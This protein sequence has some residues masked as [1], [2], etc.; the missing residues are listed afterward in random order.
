MEQHVCVHRGG[1]A[2]C[3]CVCV[4]VFIVGDMPCVCVF[5]PHT[6]CTVIINTQYPRWLRTAPRT[7]PL[8]M[9]NDK[10]KKWRPRFSRNG[11]GAGSYGFLL[12]NR[13]EFCT[14]SRHDK[15]VS[16]T[17]SMVEEKNASAALLK[18]LSPQ[19]DVNS[20]GVELIIS[21]LWSILSGFQSLLCVTEPL[22][23]YKLFSSFYC[24]P[25]FSILPLYCV[26]WFCHVWYDEFI[27]N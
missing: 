2:L 17:P 20:I 13:L 12:N 21:Y 24:F 22:L 15:C 4:C 27:W 1:Y 10:K 23:L 18:C 25:T 7:K 16:N 11:R 6:D 19:L 3:V 5:S 14:R 9:R 8:L 26:C